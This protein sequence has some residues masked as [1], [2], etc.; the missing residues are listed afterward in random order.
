MEYRNKIIPY[1]ISML[2]GIL[3]VVCVQAGPVELPDSARPGAIRPDHD[4]SV[5]QAKVPQAGPVKPQDTARPSAVR[6]GQKAPVPV[7]KVPQAGPVGLPD[8][9][10]PGA[11]RPGQ[12][13]SAP[14]AKVPQAGT[15]D[16]MEIPAVIDRP[17]NVEEC[18]CI[19]AREFRLLQAEDMP[20]YGI[21]L[22][23]VQKILEA[24]VKEQPAEGYSIGK[25]QE[26]ANAVRTYYRERGLILT[27]VVIPVQNVQGGV[28]DFEIY[29]GK[30][31]RILAEGNKM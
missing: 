31:G 14:I 21:V 29:V 25:M 12:E 11:V 8:T 13:A 2:M 1:L 5:P 17:F 15:T 10:R 20:E 9:A 30:L 23:D 28:V 3:Y 22:A 6:P 19:V 16:T 24:K 27:Q 26:V 4:A 7:A 18:P